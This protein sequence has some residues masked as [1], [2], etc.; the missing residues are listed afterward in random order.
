VKIVLLTD[1][2]ENRRKAKDE[3]IFACSIGDYV[4][5]L[6]DAP[7][8]QDKLSLKEYGS[9]NNTPLY[10]PHLTLVQI[11]DGIKNGKLYQ[12]SY[13]AS[14]ENF[15]EGS[16]NVEGFE[17]FVSEISSIFVRFLIDS[18]RRFSFRAASRSTELSTVT[19]SL[20]NFSQSPS[21][22]RRVKSCWKTKPKIQPTTRSTT[23][24]KP[25]SS[26]SRT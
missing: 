5:S 24:T 10:P 3:G 16:V 21:G 25:R 23:K 18:L 22:L 26:C 19:S 12:G 15:L 1:D 9:E 11:H 8:L 17:K 2:A 7:H 14:R 4:R 6:T 13:V 20:S